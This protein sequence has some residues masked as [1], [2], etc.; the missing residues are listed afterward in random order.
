MTSKSRYL[1][2]VSV[3]ISFKGP[4]IN[5]LYSS[6]CGIYVADR[7]FTLGL[8][9]A[10][11]QSTTLLKT[12]LKMRTGIHRAMHGASGLIQLYT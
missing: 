3:K 4:F 6:K 2:N 10:L 11:F 5:C 12:L 9:T 1:K 8:E 7:S